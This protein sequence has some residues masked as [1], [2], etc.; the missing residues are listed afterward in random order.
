MKNKNSFKIFIIISFAE[1]DDFELFRI[2]FVEKCYRNTN[3][4]IIII[5]NVGHLIDIYSI[6]VI[7]FRIIF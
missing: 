2:V 1:L 5:R 7:I 4:S 6:V 3:R